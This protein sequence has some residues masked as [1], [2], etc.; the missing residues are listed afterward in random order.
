MNSNQN[1]PGNRL[2]ISGGIILAS[3]SPRRKQLLE[4]AEVNFEVVVK[5]TDESYPPGL[6]ADEIAM[7]IARN[8]A[9]AV[10]EDNH[11]TKPVL[12]ADTIVVLDEIVIG[13]PKSRED[14]IATLSALSGRKHRVVTGVII[15]YKHQETAFADTTEV[16]FHPLTMEQIVFYVDKYKPYD[17]AGA[18]AIQEWIGVTGI[19][20]VSGD[21]Y[22]VMGLPVSRVVQALQKLG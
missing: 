3:Q 6:F 2:L 19:K 21:F 13:K 5:E 7:H 9:L 15:Q 10:Q 11:F 1:F 20:S 17:K 22:N 16:E 12:S 4:W 18:Y 14:A 8:K